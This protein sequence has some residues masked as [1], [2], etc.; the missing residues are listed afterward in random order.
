[1]YYILFDLET[2]GKEYVD[3]ILTAS[4][5]CYD[6]NLSE[7]VDE[8]N[9]KVKVSPSQLPSPEAIVVNKIDILKHNEEGISE[10]EA[11]KIIHDFIDSFCTRDETYLIGFNSTKFD[12]PFLRT[13]LIRNGYKPYFNKNLNYVDTIDIVKKLFYTNTRFYELIQDLDNKG[14]KSLSLNNI[15][16][17]LGLNNSEQTHDAKDDVL[18]MRKLL[19]Y[20]MKQFKLELNCFCCYEPEI[21]I[22]KKDYILSKL[23][24]FYDKDG[25]RKSVEE[26]FVK[27]EEDKTQALWINLDKYIELK[28]SGIDLS[29]DKSCVFWFNKKTS[30][31]IVTD[32]LYDEDDLDKYKEIENIAK[33]A[34]KELSWIN[35]QNYF[36][37][38]NCDIEQF[39][40]M[41]SFKE[42]DALSQAIL[43][44]NMFF[45]D[46][47]ES[48]YPRIL[49]NRYR[50]NTEPDKYEKIL[51]DYI[52]YRYSGKMKI[53]KDDYTSVYEEGVFN[54]NFH[55]TLN[56]YLDKIN[57]LKDDVENIYLLDSLEKFYKS[58]YIY[59]LCYDELIKIKRC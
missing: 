12:V 19:K 35:L 44:N 3:Q 59:K 29:S 38:K 22:G 4:F 17:S 58:S 49:L 43:M 34:K 40:Y 10:Q 23:N 13:T 33:V 51:K 28:K 57:E 6:K 36:P 26:C 41:M 53:E 48:K 52:M 2:S 20:L 14:Y 11:C 32:I 5:I 31:F 42:L 18:L 47:L 54:K 8:L 30:P 25:V 56:E 37:Q 15:T 45:M 50:M 1:M 39:I 55:P 9:L 46:K 7:I 24:Y 27:L 16:K 21:L